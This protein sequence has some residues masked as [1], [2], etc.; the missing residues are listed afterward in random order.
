MTG[1]DLRERVAGLDDVARAV[2][3]SDLRRRPDDRC[4]VRRGPVPRSGVR[5]ADLGP[6]HLRGTMLRRPRAAAPLAVQA[7]LRRAPPPGAPPPPGGPAPRP[8][9]LG[10]AAG[11]VSPR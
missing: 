10:A 3:G 9:D 7:Q 2:G 5:L 4:P 8:A 1:G 6:R 11:L